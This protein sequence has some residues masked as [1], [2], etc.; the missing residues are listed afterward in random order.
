M[1]AKFVNLNFLPFIGIFVLFAF[2]LSWIK[3]SF[4]VYKKKPKNGFLLLLFLSF[5]FIYFSYFRLLVDV[6]YYQIKISNSFSDVITKSNWP[7]IVDLIS[8]KGHE[9]IEC[10]VFPGIIQSLIRLTSLR[11]GMPAYVFN[12]EG[13][14]RS[15][16]K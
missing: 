9:Y 15:V 3:L 7:F 8:A 14:L 5:L 16:P 10:E 6:Y 2:S 11:S 4:Y 1:D 13:K 12:M